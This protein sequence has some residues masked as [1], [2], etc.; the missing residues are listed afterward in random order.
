[1]RSA[2]H[3]ACSPT[4]R[5]RWCP[6]GGARAAV[7][8]PSHLRRL[9]NSPHSAVTLLAALLAEREQ[10]VTDSLADLVVATVHRIG[11]RAEQKVTEELINL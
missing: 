7:E 9:P 8:S 3:P 6:G 1:M 2:C 4:S 5:R 10:D 11:A